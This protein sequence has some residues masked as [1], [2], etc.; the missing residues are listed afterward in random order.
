MKAQDTE[1]WVLL[2][3]T[4]VF[5]AISI[6]CIISVLLAPDSVQIALNLSLS[7][8]CIVL[9]F[10]CNELSPRNRGRF[11]KLLLPKTKDGLEAEEVADLQ[12]R[13][14]SAGYFNRIGLVGIPLAVALLAI[15]L[16]GLYFL[17]EGLHYYSASSTFLELMKL[18]IGAFIG[19]LSGVRHQSDQ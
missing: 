19:A 13:V 17:A 10:V 8:A 12:R 9:A 15:L 1:E 16:M 2:A 6:I 7:G 5:L 4:T 18:T 11:L 3:A 14:G